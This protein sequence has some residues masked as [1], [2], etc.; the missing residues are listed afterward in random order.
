LATTGRAVAQ[1]IKHRFQGQHE[2]QHGTALMADPRDVTAIIEEWPRPQRKVAE[3]MIAKYG[4]PNEACPT[5]LFWYHNSPWKRT[6]IT[7]DV[8]EHH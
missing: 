7:S 5:K 8:V 4:P 1:G 2:T 3:Q 6:E